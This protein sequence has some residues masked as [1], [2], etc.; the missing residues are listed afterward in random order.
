MT[1]LSKSISKL[2]LLIAT[3]LVCIAAN[4]QLGQN[5]EELVDYETQSNAVSV[6]SN[7]TIKLRHYEIPLRLIEKEISN[8]T[9]EIIKKALTFEKNDEKYIR[10]IINPEDTKWHLEV[11][12]WLKTNK[13]DA[14]PKTHFEAHMTAS[15]SYIVRDPE[16]GA[17]MSMKVSTNQT[18]GFWKDK[19]QSWDDAQ[20]TKLAADVVAEMVEKRTPDNFIYLDEP[21][22]F[23]IKAL[24]QGMIIRMLGELPSKGKHYIP[25]FSV[26]HEEEGKH[27]AK[28]N[29]SDDP[30]E[31][32]KEHY[33][34]PLGRGI[35]E[36]FAM[37]GL[38]YDSPHSQNFLVELDNNFKPTGKIV[39]RDLGD[40]YAA[41]EVIE[42][43]GQTKLLKIWERGNMLKGRIMI[44][45]G[46]LHGNSKPSWISEK[47]YNAYGTA[48]FIEFEKELSRVTAV[49][50]QQLFADGPFSRSGDY[51]S[52]DY[53]FGGKSGWIDYLSTIGKTHGLVRSANSCS[54]VF[55]T[56]L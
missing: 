36:L 44:A 38:A 37:T 31:F 40:S 16:T 48:F 17:E 42:A 10:W 7:E 25:G 29:G 1:Q 41:Q 56:G 11:A 21:A 26:L 4:A 28:L 45:Q 18:G 55:S 35:A 52:K 24:D 32:W 34:K 43:L 46:V 22:V 53:S 5:V 14:E 20:Q 49:P 9:P 3:G 54:V 8:R 13:V 39:F 27:I 12:Q 23:G 2:T 6:R 47:Q 33:I 15:R 19:K 50:L 30:A 51:F